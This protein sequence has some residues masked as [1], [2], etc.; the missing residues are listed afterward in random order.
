MT[1]DERKKAREDS[2]DEEGEEE[3]GLTPASQSPEAVERR[4]RMAETKLFLKAKQAE[5]ARERIAG[6][7]NEDEE[8]ESNEEEKM[9]QSS[10]LL[11]DEG[12]GNGNGADS[13]DLVNHPHVEL[14]DDTV[15]PNE[16]VA[17]LHRELGARTKSLEDAL[18]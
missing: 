11:A 6:I 4:R 5:V 8:E 15:D 17:S 13:L 14:L 9:E 7:L 1:D 16:E 18:A 12:D 10:N 2:D 3:E